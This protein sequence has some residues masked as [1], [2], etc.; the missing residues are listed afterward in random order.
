MAAEPQPTM[1]L[2]SIRYDRVGNLISRKIVRQVPDDGSIERGYRLLFEMA[3]DGLK[4]KEEPQANA[5]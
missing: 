3:C 5:E 1:N 2:I 4:R